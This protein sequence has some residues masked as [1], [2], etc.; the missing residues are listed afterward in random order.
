VYPV[1][2][3][4][5]AYLLNKRGFGIHVLAEAIGASTR[6]VHKWVVEIRGS[7]KGMSGW[8]RKR[9]QRMGYSYIAPHLR[10]KIKLWGRLPHEHSF[11]VAKARECFQRLLRWIYFR[12]HHGYLDLYACLRGEEPP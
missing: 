6:T 8:V 3:K 2:F 11:M 4:S 1:E 12:D 9:K 10:G 7:L 5:F